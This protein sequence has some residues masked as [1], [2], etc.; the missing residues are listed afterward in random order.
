MLQKLLGYLIKQGRL[1]VHIGA[2]SSTART[3][4]VFGEVPADRP[5]LDVVIAFDS[6]AT[7]QSVGV[8][9]YLRLGEAWTDGRMTVE[10]GDLWSFMVLIGANLG[11]MPQNNGFAAF[12]NR[13]KSM[14][15][16]HSFQASRQHVAHHYDLSERLYR[17]FL[18]EDMQY[19]CAYFAR[20]DVSLEEAQ[21][22]KKQHIADKLYLTPGM[23]VLDIGCGWGGMAMH[24]AREAKAKVTG[25]TL[26]T[27]QMAVAVAR[28]QAS[29]LN[30]QVRFELCDYRKA[31][32]QYDRVVSVG[33]FEHVGV[34]GFDGYFRTV[35]ERLKDDGVA[36]IH[37]IGRRGETGGRSAW[38][39]KYIFPGG[40]IPSLTEITRA[41]EKSGL[42]VTDIEMLRLHYAE[43]MK[44]WRQRFEAHRDEIRALYDERFCR[45][46][47]FY[48]CYC[49]LGFRYGNMM[50]FQLQLTKQIDTLPI[51]RDYMMPVA[52]SSIV[53]DFEKA[54]SKLREGPRRVV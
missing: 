39:D 10:S 38:L 8:N 48:L 44:A 45:M 32:G 20:P 27:E 15:P 52:E 18:D 31:R 24:L 2:A 30:E 12:L 6:L 17:L 29:N 46:W 21:A 53:V 25:I 4:W 13:V 23:S 51:T 28:A 7:A 3:S 34:A 35:A 42:W 41:A 5:E 9:P 26:S 11:H 47:E 37:T 43:T 1:T 40:Y 49:E 36:V 19:S 50:V 33:M 14:M 16:A 22:A 54:A